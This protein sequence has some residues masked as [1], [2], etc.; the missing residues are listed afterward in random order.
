MF[1]ILFETNLKQ[2]RPWSKAKLRVSTSLPLIKS[3]ANRGPVSEG[4]SYRNDLT[5][6]PS[7]SSAA[8]CRARA[9]PV[10]I[11]S[12]DGSHGNRYNHD[13]STDGWICHDCSLA[14]SDFIDTK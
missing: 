12:S 8:S 6:S 4:L 5:P 11:L 14:I 13:L 7:F 2:N 9:A 10:V 3:H 1:Q